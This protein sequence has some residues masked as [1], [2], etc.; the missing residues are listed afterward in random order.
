LSKDNLLAFNHTET[1]LTSGL[2]KADRITP[3]QWLFV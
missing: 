3:T 1:S 2:K